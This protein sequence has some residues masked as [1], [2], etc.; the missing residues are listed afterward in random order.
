MKLP[1]LPAVHAG[2]I[3]HFLNQ[4]RTVLKLRLYGIPNPM[5]RVATFNDLVELG[6]VSEDEARKQAV[7]R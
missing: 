6:L 4:I 7:K 2:N 3:M 1:M 5:H